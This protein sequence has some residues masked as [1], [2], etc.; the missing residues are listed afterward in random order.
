MNKLNF[1]SNIS[2]YSLEPEENNSST[3]NKT[4]N[5]DITNEEESSSEKALKI[6]E[7][8][9][10]EKERNEPY[11]M[12][13]YYPRYLHPEAVSLIAQN[14]L[15]QWED[16]EVSNDDNSNNNNQENTSRQQK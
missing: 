10:K 2:D 13:F 6:E 9:R 16:E 7:N 11:Q 5:N 8:I 3:S 14:L 1:R 15:N 4:N 12:F